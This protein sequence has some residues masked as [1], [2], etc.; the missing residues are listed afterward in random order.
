MSFFQSLPGL[1]NVNEVLN[2]IA[3][4][5]ALTPLQDDIKVL[6][7]MTKYKLKNPEGAQSYCKFILFDAYNLD[8]LE[9]QLYEK[10]A[11]KAHVNLIELHI[12]SDGSHKLV[13]IREKKYHNFKQ[14]NGT[15]AVFRIMKILRDALSSAK[16]DAYVQHRY[17]YHLIPSGFWHYDENWY[18]L[19]ADH[20]AFGKIASQESILGSVYFKE[21]D[22]NRCFGH[23]N[24]ITLNTPVPYTTLINLGMYTTPWLQVLEAVYHEYGKEQLASVSKTSIEAFI[25]DYITKYELDISSSDIPFLAKFIR[26]AEQKE[27]K[28]YH[29][30]KK[31]QESIMRHSQSNT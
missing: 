11:S 30:K 27:G 23:T 2:R 12:L 21:E 13:D 29:V 7:W 10:S 25:Q 18:R 15:F 6:G 4:Q 28:K 9:S 16:L 5:A 22:V 14:T 24:Q 3:A 20:Y 8:S 1:L 19:L 17:D 26:L 31:Q